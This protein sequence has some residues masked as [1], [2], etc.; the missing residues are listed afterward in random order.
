MEIFWVFCLGVLYLAGSL[1]TFHYILTGMMDIEKRNK[2]KAASTVPETQS[3]FMK[4]PIGEKML[5]KFLT[6]KK[7]QE[8]RRLKR[9]GLVAREMVP[10][11]NK[12]LTREDMKSFPLPVIKNEE[13][14]RDFRRPM[15]GVFIGIN[16]RNT[17]N[18]LKGCITDVYTALNFY[19]PFLDEWIILTDDT[20]HK[21]TRA[22]ILAAFRWL[23]QKVDSSPDE[24]L[25]LWYSG[26]GGLTK[27]SSGDE[28]SG[29]D[30]VIYPIDNTVILDDT[31]YYNTVVPMEAFPNKYLFMC[32]DCC[33]NGTGADL[34][35]NASTSTERTVEVARG[36]RHATR[37]NVKLVSACSDPQTAA[38]VQDDPSRIN[39]GA[40]TK[41]FFTVEQLLSPMTNPACTWDLFLRH[42]R[43]YLMSRGYSQIPQFSSTQ[44]FRFNERMTIVRP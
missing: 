20:P 10:F 34:E 8:E 16:Y 4:D 40:F 12:P 31:I 13:K 6:I 38:D 39:F 1:A 35:F 41:A 21:P 26:H 24:N 25:V 27:D 43:E 33:H 14:S 3:F 42:V 32:F 19:K 17:L 11:V 44:P 15:R 7:E 2:S 23:V 37:A 36:T 5:M 28:R 29:Q 18:E 9:S 30:S 22:N